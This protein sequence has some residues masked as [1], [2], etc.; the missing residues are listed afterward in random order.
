VGLEVVSDMGVRLAVGV[1]GWR[2][3]DGVMGLMEVSRFGWWRENLRAVS[4]LPPNLEG[5]SYPRP[6]TYFAS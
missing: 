4:G 3:V 2:L 5:T 1:E 6:D